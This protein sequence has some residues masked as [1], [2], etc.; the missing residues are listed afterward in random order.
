MNGT[1]LTLCIYIKIL[2]IIIKI[3][4]SLQSCHYKHRD[5]NNKYLIH[6]HIATVSYCE[7]R[8]RLLKVFKSNK[9]Y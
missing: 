3:Q 9:I 8:I 7:L 4:K 1:V 2:V 6:I 5:I